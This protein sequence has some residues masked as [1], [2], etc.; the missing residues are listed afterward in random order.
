M[1]AALAVKKSVIV[2]DY[3][4][5]PE[6]GFPATATCDECGQE[7]PITADHWFRFKGVTDAE[8]QAL[9][10]FHVHGKN[11]HKRCSKEYRDG[12]KGDS[13][14]EV[15]ARGSNKAAVLAATAAQVATLEAQYLGSPS[16]EFG[17]YTPAPVVEVIPEPEAI[18]PVVEPEPIAE[19]EPVVETSS[20]VVEEPVHQPSIAT[21]MDVQVSRSRGRRN[22]K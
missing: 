19:P 22:R 5:F 13:E 10:A 2:A 11:C 21:A 15:H 17:G 6:T 20:E 8:G 9:P 4:E 14:R 7:L 18:A 12:L 16:Y 3:T 1:S